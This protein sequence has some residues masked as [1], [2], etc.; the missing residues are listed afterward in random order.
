MR[1]MQIANF[2]SPTSG[3]IRT[4]LGHWAQ[5]YGDRGHDIAAV[6]PDHGTP[7]VWD[8]PADV[9]LARSRQAP[10]APG[11]RLVT[12]RAEVA[13]AV[14]RFAPDVLE[15]SDRT[16]L[17]WLARWARSRGIASVLVSHES[18]T[19]VART[20]GVPR[21]VAATLASGIHRGGALPFDAV[22]APSRFAARELRL[23]GVRAR[24]VPLGVDRATFHPAPLD[25]KADA[26]AG[27]GQPTGASPLRLLH[28]GRLSQEKYPF[29]SVKTLIE[30]VLWGVDAELVVVGDGP[31]RERVQRA[32][33]G[34]PVTFLGHLDAE[35]VG[36]HMRASD[37]VLAPA[38]AET[39]GLAALEALACGTPVVCGTTGALPEVVGDGGRVVPASPTAF[40]NAV[41]ALTRD[42]AVAARVRARARD[43]AARLTWEASAGAMLEVHRDAVETCRART[44][45]VARVARAGRALGAA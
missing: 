32:A 25:V 6:I 3:G 34:F 33:A 12:A 26:D 15:I 37:V 8:T 44:P 18:V 4:A 17:R 45:R 1:I 27:A 5:Q 28:V 23:A 16:T 11:Y 9:T 40:A 31:H 42:P 41:L 22:V 24:V 19:D 30:L 7:W 21:P 39:F 36:E 29:L 14:T 13:D 38:P 35:E 20:Y 2:V 10:G 43:R